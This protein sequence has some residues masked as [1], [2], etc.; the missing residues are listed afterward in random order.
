MKKERRSY[1]DE[2]DHKIEAKPMLSNHHS[3]LIFWWM[4]LTTINGGPQVTLMEYIMRYNLRYIN[5]LM[6]K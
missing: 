1:L 5:T 6:L 2:H 4:A 3:N